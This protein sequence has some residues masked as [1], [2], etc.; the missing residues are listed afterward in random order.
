LAGSFLVPRFGNMLKL[1]HD[2]GY[3]MVQLKVD[4]AAHTVETTRILAPLGRPIDL[5]ILPGH[6]IVIAEYARATNLAA[7]VGTPGRLLLLQPK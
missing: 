5:L 3:D 6:R 1:D 2:V 4:F 7:G